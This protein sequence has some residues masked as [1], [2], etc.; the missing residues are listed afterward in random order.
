MNQNNDWQ[1]MVDKEEVAGAYGS[2][3]LN[4]GSG[5]AMTYTA[6]KVQRSLPRITVTFRVEMYLDEQLS[7]TYYE[8]YVF[9]YDSAGRIRNIRLKGKSEDVLKNGLPATQKS[10]E[11]FADELM[12]KNKN[13]GNHK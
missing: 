5:C 2:F 1:I 4:C 12:K 10:F 11:D 3:V 7:D 13:I 6:E 9:S 8:T